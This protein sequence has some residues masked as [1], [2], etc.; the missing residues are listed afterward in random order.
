MI[1]G[2]GIPSH[3]LWQIMDAASG[4]LIL[5]SAASDWQGRQD[6]RP[7]QLHHRLDVEVAGL[8]AARRLESGSDCFEWSLVT[9]MVSSGMSLSVN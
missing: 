4:A 8:P 5:H 3:E 1:D 6:D 7:P 2:C 9:E